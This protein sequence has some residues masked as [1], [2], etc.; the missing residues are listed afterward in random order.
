MSNNAYDIAFEQAVEER[1]EIRAA[2]EQ[3]T[4]RGEMIDK[5]M[6]CLAPFVSVHEPFEPAAAKSEAAAKSSA[7]VEVHA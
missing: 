1:A 5:L 2:I 6:Q 3:L 4:V 7:S